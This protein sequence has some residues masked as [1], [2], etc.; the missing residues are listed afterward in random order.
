VAKIQEKHPINIRC[1]PRPN[2][3]RFIDISE[4]FKLLS[5]L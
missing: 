4:P 5:Y 1:E 3:T 2:Q